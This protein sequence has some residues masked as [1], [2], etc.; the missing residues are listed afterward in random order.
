MKL[1]GP[2]VSAESA[3]TAALN[4]AEHLYCP[5]VLEFVAEPYVEKNGATLL[6]AQVPQ[7]LISSPTSLFAE[8]KL[9]VSEIPDRW[10]WAYADWMSRLQRAHEFL[11]AS[12]YLNCAAG[13]LPPVKDPVVAGLLLY[14]SS[15]SVDSDIRAQWLD[16]A[17]QSPAGSW[18]AAEGLHTCDEREG[19]LNG[20][21]GESRLLWA[22]SQIPGF[23]AAAA[24][25][26]QRH[27]DV[28]GG[29]TVA[30]NG[31]RQ[32]F[33]AWLKKTALAACECA[34]AACAVLVLQPKAEPRDKAVWLK[35]L[36]NPKQARYAYEVVQWAKHTWP[37]EHWC[38]L[39]KGL[40]EYA[41]SDNAQ[42]A[43]HWF[44]RIE[45]EHAAAAIGSEHFDLLWGAELLALTNVDDYA[46][47]FRLGEELD[48][49]G[50]SP[51]SIVLRWLNQR[52]KSHG[53]V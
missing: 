6:Q 30:T 41:V 7:S 39:R 46:F 33:E 2:Q 32:Q 3:R 14:L 25:H 15:A 10:M 16:V 35:T 12:L 17:V 47:R 22:V 49:S 11:R 9:S 13:K 26:A 44:A 28:Y 50:H 23:G 1:F 18:L 36:Q 20:V 21:R 8:S 52:L 29:L 5:S 34:D 53:T 40:R 51:A 42:W 24:M 38:R 31:S 48:S 19:I 43:C 27:L 37:T 4:L 45:P